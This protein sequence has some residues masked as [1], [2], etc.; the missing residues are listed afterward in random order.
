MCGSSPVEL[1]SGKTK[2]ITGPSV[3]L[4]SG[5]LIIFFPCCLVCN[6]YVF[7]NTRM[8]LTL[9]IHSGMGTVRG[10]NV[11]GVRLSLCREEALSGVSSILGKVCGGCTQRVCGRW[12]LQKPEWT[13]KCT[14]R[15]KEEG[16]ILSFQVFPTG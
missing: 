3:S 16:R 9:G 4:S 12:G 5:C 11:I 7:N 6:I 13:R 14:R 1:D 8:V 15:R 2:T 10:P